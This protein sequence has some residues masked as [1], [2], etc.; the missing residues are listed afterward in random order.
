MADA[1]R[2]QGNTWP[3]GTD[4]FASRG[5]VQRTPDG[6]AGPAQSDFLSDSATGRNLSAVSPVQAVDGQLGGGTIWAGGLPGG[7][8]QAG[9]ILG[10]SS[11][12]QGHA[13]SSTFGATPGSDASNV[14]V[15]PTRGAA[16][17]PFTDASGQP[18]TNREAAHSPFSDASGQPKQP[19]RDDDEG[20][21]YKTHEKRPEIPVPSQS[22][23]GGLGSISMNVGTATPIAPFKALSFITPDRGVH[24]EM[25]LFDPSSLGEDAE[26]QLHALTETLTDSDALK[27]LVLKSPDTVVMREFHQKKNGFNDILHE[28]MDQGHITPEVANHL[29][30]KMHGQFYQHV[31]QA[32]N[33]HAM[34]ILIESFRANLTNQIPRILNQLETVVKGLRLHV[35]AG[36]LESGFDHVDIMMEID[37]TCRGIKIFGNKRDEAVRNLSMLAVNQLDDTHNIYGFLQSEMSS[38]G[39]LDSKSLDS[40]NEDVKRLTSTMATM[41][42]TCINAA[43][44]YVQR[45]A[46]KKDT[47][48][49]KQINIPAGVKSDPDAKVA[50]SLSEA[51]LD[52]LMQDTATYWPLIFVHGVLANLVLKKGMLVIPPSDKTESFGQALNMPGFLA[53]RYNAANKKL[54]AVLKVKVEDMC[55]L[56]RAGRTFD[57]GEGQ[58]VFIIADEMDGMS[59]VWFYM[60]IHAQHTTI[61]RL[62]LRDRLQHCVGLFTDGPLKPAVDRVRVDIELAAQFTLHVEPHAVLSVML[63]TLANRDP[64]FLELYREYERTEGKMTYANGLSI[65]D[66]YLTKIETTARSMNKYETPMRKAYLTE[67]NK[68]LVQAN[69]FYGALEAPAP[70]PA[71][72]P[73]PAPAPAPAPAQA[74]AEQKKTAAVAGS[75]EQLKCNAKDCMETIAKDQCEKYEKL[76]KVFPTCHRPVCKK[77]WGKMMRGKGSADIVHKTGEMTKYHEVNSS[78]SRTANAK[79]AAAMFLQE[80][81]QEKA[82]PMDKID[83]VMEAQDQMWKERSASD[84]LE[85]LNKISDML[86]EHGSVCQISIMEEQERMKQE[87]LYYKM[88]SYPGDSG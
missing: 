78:G 2:G 63:K 28:V 29:S 87:D 50:R 11:V 83:Q 67:S 49:M 73:S 86:G 88:M 45:T 4:P 3:E 71:P 64:L 51:L 31:T 21:W 43:C 16:H 82:D 58:A 80:C 19:R 47:L 17:S 26:G 8:M 72:A 85:Q 6:A 5:N 76:L 7:S 20:R 55:R 24:G 70:T 52:F 77:C 46:P 30:K 18:T 33:D 1:M 59:V 37:D 34:P 79:K 39:D 14:G 61:S 56:A 68:L 66:R 65:I 35:G 10:M 40:G 9:T 25:S 23:L 57:F 74:P 32:F 44:L 75:G 48:T 69:A 36:S 54:Y 42:R 15:K 22:A 13:T 60:L 12:T 41:E 27:D 53:E 81:E 84:R 38:S 62:Q